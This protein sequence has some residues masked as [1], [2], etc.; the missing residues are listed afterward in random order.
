M[1]CKDE[2]EIYAAPVR[3]GIHRRIL[4]WDPAA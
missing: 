4:N 2:I 3:I 1:G